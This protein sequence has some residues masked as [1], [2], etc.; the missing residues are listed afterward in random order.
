VGSAIRRHIKEKHGAVPE[1]TYHPRSVSLDPGGMLYIG[2]DNAPIRL[3]FDGWSV[4]VRPTNVDAYLH[5]LKTP[6]TL[7][8][9]IQVVKMPHVVGVVVLSP[10][11]ADLL[12]SALSGDEFRKGTLLRAKVRAELA[13][14]PHV[15][16]NQA[17]GNS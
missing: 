8:G 6:P 12:A 10:M 3:A 5:L 9:G 2:E 15:H 14:S 4:Y 16:I 17:V 11:E 13:L 7:R 1:R